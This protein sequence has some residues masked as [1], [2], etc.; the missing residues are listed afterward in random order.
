MSDDA[1]KERD[2]DLDEQGADDGDEP[3]DEAPADDR[4]AKAA[5]R[6]KK[7]VKK[8][9]LPT[10]PSDERPAAA[11][12]A[13]PGEQGGGSKVLLAAVVALV[14]GVAIGWFVRESRGAA[15]VEA[16][17]DPALA[18]ASPSG[19]AAAAGPCG[20]WTAAVCEGAGETS[21]SCGQAKAAADLLP[22]AACV[23]AMTE[24][25]TTLEKIKSARGICDELVKKLCADVGP[26][27]ESCKLVTEKTP[28]FPTQQCKMMMEKYDKVLGELKAMEAKN[29]PLTPEVAAK[30]AAG[31]APG[32]GPKD[33]KVTV[34]EYSDFECPFCSRA[35]DAVNELKKKYGDKVRFV[36]RQYPL[37]M[38]KNAQL[39]AE[40]SLA[41][42][43]QGKFWQMHDLLFANQRELD[44]AS[45]EKYA[46]Q[47]GL[48]MD[49]FKK[50]LD[51]RSYKDEVEADMK[52]GGE[53]GVSGTPTMIVGTQ[54]VQNPTDAAAVSSLIDEQLSR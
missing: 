21:E 15:G 23:Q 26:D 48:D 2:E 12:N 36:F 51:D 18:A 13:A 31:A 7:K 4:L 20:Q 35:A 29:A 42:D 41:A 22:P 9:R 27:T 25:G 38:H 6:R 1:D 3:R 11:G 8:K 37:P 30:Q 46:A 16:T 45:L 28:Q 33:A 14:V 17:P 40:A 49:K 44:R 5:K 10:P 53:I 24:V 52:L 47:I 50:A 34:V 39:A 43:A 54:R 32:F 19:S